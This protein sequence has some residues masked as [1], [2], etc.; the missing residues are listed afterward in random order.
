LLSRRRWLQ[1]AA[2]L[3]GGGLLAA[4]APTPPAQ[5]QPPAAGAGATT[6]PAGAAKP[7]G[8]PQ[9]APAAGG[10]SK[11]FVFAVKTEAPT[12]DPAASDAS[13]F[14]YPQRAM[15]EPLL[16]NAADASGNVTLKPVL[17]ERWE[18]GADGKSYT[19]YL[20]KG[21]TFTDGSE[22]NAEAV[23]WTFDRLLAQKTPVTARVPSLDS[24][25]ALDAST[26][27]FNL[28][29]PFAPFLASMTLPLIQSPTTGKKNE[30]DGD[31]GKAYWDANP[32]GT[33][34]YKLERW[35]RG[36]QFV[37]ARNTEYWGGWDGQHLDRMILK[38]VKE[39]STHRQLLETGDA[40]LSDGI[41]FDDLDAL[42]KVPE[43][44]V[45][46]QR[47][48][49]ILNI[50]LH[51]QKPPFDNVKVRQ[52][53]SYAFDY[54]AIVK[55]VFNGRGRQ[56]KG[57]VMPGT[58]GEDQTLQPYT[59]DLEK[60]KALITEA[61]LPA[62]TRARIMTISP[63]GWYQPREAQILQ[64]N[65]K[66]LGIEATI[67][68][69]SDAATFFATFQNKETGMDVYMYESIQA[70]DDPDYELRRM[71]HSSGLKLRNGMWFENK[72]FD[73]LLDKAMALT[74]R[75]Q[76]KPIYAEIQ[77]LLHEQAPAIW[78]ASLDYF[79][80]RRKNVQGYVW[81]PF[82]Q[83]IPAYHSLSLGS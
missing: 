19:F 32:V 58:W 73:D 25:E 66:E 53:V 47:Q 17:A 82:G 52:A 27:K 63:F 36:Q 33:G 15:Y 24:V 35:D 5:S 57:P 10:S 76:R 83:G 41:A 22:M 40:H 8:A 43:V 49:E 23:K 56:P 20:R 79:L 13:Y 26:V 61:N 67:E 42:G 37:F 30:K 16:E 55:G 3:A 70:L 51:T 65:L 50:C 38:V 11:P 80:T 72:Q 62:G 59:R 12:L 74:D 75:E 28:K 68:D 2:L 4:C 69:K 7:T 64:A 48:P 1:A 9:A 34:P 46:P 21:V 60:A 39:A 54:D 31:W 45:E 6:A 71:Y 29:T 77:Q 78:P 14:R 44:L 81:N 18:T